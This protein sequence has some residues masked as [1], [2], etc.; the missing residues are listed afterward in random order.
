AGS[1]YVAKS[2]TLTFQPGETSKGIAVQVFGDFMWESD[3]TFY[4][5]LSNGANATIANAE[6]AGTIVND[7][8]APPT[9]SINAS[10]SVTEGDFGTT[11]AFFQFTLSAPSKQTITLDYATY[12]VTATAGSDYIAK[13]GTLTFQPGETSKGIAVEVVG[14]LVFEPDETF[15]V[16][17]AN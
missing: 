5:N 7:D 13:S 3:E 10:T 14:D 9:V 6:G 17:L 2:G 8:A 16:G 1:D 15:I 12:D 11:N 4:V